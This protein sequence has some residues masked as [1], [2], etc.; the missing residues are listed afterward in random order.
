VLSAHREGLW[1]HDKDTGRTQDRAPQQPMADALVVMAEH[2]ASPSAATGPRGDAQHRGAARVDGRPNI[3][4]LVLACRDCHILVHEGRRTLIRGP[5][6]RWT[7][8][9]GPSPS[10]LRGIV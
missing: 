7:L 4:L 8:D 2:G 1:R 10:D 3:D 5:D 9:P 6:G